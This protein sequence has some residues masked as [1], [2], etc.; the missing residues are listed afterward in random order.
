MTDQPHS[1]N[2]RQLI[3]DSA[4]FGAA[5]GLAV[6]GGEVVSHVAG[7]ADAARIQARPTVRFAQVS[8]SHIGFS[9]RCGS[10]FMCSA[11]LTAISAAAALV[12]AQAGKLSQAPSPYPGI[13][14]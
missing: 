3:R 13:P 2:R 14:L 4:W 9:A 5:V 6:V 1:M 7:T 10:P 11:R 8:D 12:R